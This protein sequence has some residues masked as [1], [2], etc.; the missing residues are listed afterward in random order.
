MG[1]HGG[2]DMTITEKVMTLI[3]VIV[4]AMA[5]LVVYVVLGFAGYLGWFE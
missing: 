5:C 1:D 3:A 4:T 2:D